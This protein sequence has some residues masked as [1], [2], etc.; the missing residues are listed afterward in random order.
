MLNIF[1]SF[2]LMEDLFY[3][4]KY[5]IVIFLKNYY[6]DLNFFLKINNL[7]LFF[8]LILIY[9]FELLELNHLENNLYLLNFILL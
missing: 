3:Q 6:I 1:Y 4:M 7:I 2:D 9:Y 5:Y 8:F